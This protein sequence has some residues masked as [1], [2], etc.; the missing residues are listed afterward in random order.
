MAS[1]SEVVTTTIRPELVVIPNPTRARERRLRRLA[2]RL[3]LKASK[4]RRGTWAL[5]AATPAILRGQ[6]L[7]TVEALLQLMVEVICENH[8]DHGIATGQLKSRPEKS[9]GAK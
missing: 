3:N 8:R 6:P 2:G 1:L 4:S 7:T 5:R 9:G